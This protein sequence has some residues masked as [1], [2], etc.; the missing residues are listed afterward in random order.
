MHDG[1]YSRINCQPDEAH[2]VLKIVACGM[3]HPQNQII[4]FAKLARWRSV[5]ICMPAL[6]LV[7][8]G[9]VTLLSRAQPVVSA[10]TLVGFLFVPWVILRPMW[11]LLLFVWLAHTIDGVKRL[12]YAVS[13]FSQADV[14]A[15]LIVPVLVA[16]ALYIKIFFLKW[17]GD[18]S[19]PPIRL[20]KL[21]PVLLAMVGGALFMLR[22][23]LD[24]Q[25]ITS[26]YTLVCYVPAGIAVPYILYNSSRQ[27]QFTRTLFL[28]V[29]VLALYGISQAIHGPWGYEASYLRSGLT[30][31]GGALDEDYFRAFSLLNNGST[32]AGV[33]AMGTLLS[34][35]Y[36]CRSDGRIRFRRSVVALSIFTVGICFAATQRGAMICFLITLATIPLFDRPKLFLAASACGVVILG[37]IIKWAHQLKEFMYVSNDFLTPHASGAFL[38]RNAN[39]L[40]FGQRLDGFADIANPAL[41]TPFGSVQS[42]RSEEGTGAHDLL[43][44]LLALFGYVGTSIILTVAVLVVYRGLQGVKRPGGSPFIRLWIQANLAVV[45]FMLIWGF[46]LGPAMHVSPMN[47]YFWS[48][49]GNLS[50]AYHGLGQNEPEPTPVPPS[51]TGRLGMERLPLRSPM[52][53]PPRVS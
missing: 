10:V 1:S 45:F 28:I 6:A 12:V 33:M 29:L 49:I 40:T 21:W 16:S 4:Q 24:F 11:G 27:L 13:T 37:A 19:S 41:W 51:M 2:L 52:K 30:S 14:A 53:P 20:F 9:V 39:L 48:S 50:F 42:M 22:G 18:R 43:S 32:F 34:F 38:E 35:V 17:F 7:C 5:A 3:N 26:N 25:T 47:F 15:I 46:L 44:N 31:I 36:L 8:L 23:G